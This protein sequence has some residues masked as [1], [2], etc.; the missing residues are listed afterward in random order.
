MHQ[1]LAERLRPVNFDG[2]IGQKH[3]VA[4]GAILRNIYTNNRAGMGRPVLDTISERMDAF[5]EAADRF[6]DGRKTEKKEPE[7]SDEPSCPAETPKKRIITSSGVQ[8]ADDKE[9]R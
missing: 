8:M 6:F 1:P 9:T 5:F 2:Y 7:P 3:L 4:K